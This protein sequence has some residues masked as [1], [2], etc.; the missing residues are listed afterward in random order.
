MKFVEFSPDFRCVHRGLVG[1]FSYDAYCFLY[2]WKRL[3][4]GGRGII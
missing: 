2:K 4:G 1:V 3:G